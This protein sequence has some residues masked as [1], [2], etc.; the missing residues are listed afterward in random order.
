MTSDATTRFSSR[1][2][3]YVRYRPSYP[4]AILHLLLQECG[5]SVDSVVADVGSGTGI[6][7]ELL[8]R[9]GCE[10][11]GV[12]PNAEMRAAG[13]RLLA[14]KPR[15]R[16][17]AGTAE[18][19]GLPDS[20]VDLITAAQAFHWFRPEPTRSEFLR[21]LRP[22]Y[23]V[24]LIWNERRLHG[25]AFLA[26]YEKLLQTYALDYQ[27][28][29]HR[30]LDHSDISS[31]YGHSRWKLSSFSNRQ[32]FDFEG[33]RGRLLSSSYAPHAGMPGYEAMLA[34]L[35]RLFEAHHEN[36]TIAFLYDTQV[37]YGSL[38]G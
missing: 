29:D 31:F 21:I 37:Y 13:D 11:I 34:E 10:V 6:L 20:S 30:R 23:R 24:A 8:L 7:S 38:V 1:V 26:G 4:D 35:R 36:G 22:P 3:D 33:V 15:F 18:A 32:D 12:E 9:S 17:I 19:T 16:S 5:L 27:R 14:G 25:T 28:V 2:A